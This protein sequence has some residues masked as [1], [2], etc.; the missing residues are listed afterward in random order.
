M[1]SR[2]TTGTF[3]HFRQIRPRHF[4]CCCSQ[5]KTCDWRQ[6]FALRSKSQEEVQYSRCE[7]CGLAYWATWELSGLSLTSEDFGILLQGRRLY[8]PWC[9]CQKD[10][11]EEG[12]ETRFD[13]QGITT[14]ERLK[15]DGGKSSGL[16]TPTQKESGGFHFME[17][18]QIRLE[19][20]VDMG[21]NEGIGEI[22]HGDDFYN[23]VVEQEH[24]ETQEVQTE[25]TIHFGSQE[26]GEDDIDREIAKMA[27]RLFYS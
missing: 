8:C 20:E 24:K 17:R 10:T 1:R 16:S 4:L 3:S 13:R 27:E 9:G 7:I 18:A 14:W 19:S 21:G 5:G 26:Y 2:Q 23:K 11:S 12:W 25:T 6:S 15:L 22:Q